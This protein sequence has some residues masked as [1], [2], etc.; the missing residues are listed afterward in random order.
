LRAELTFGVVL[1]CFFLSGFAALL[2]ETVWTRE[3]SFVFGTSEL[4]VATVLAGYMGGLALGAGLAARWTSRVRR[5][6]LAYGLLELGIALSAL[7]VPLAVRASTALTAALFGGRSELPDASGVGIALFTLG[8]SFAILLLPTAMMGATLPMLARHAVRSEQEIGSRVGL[9]YAANTV[10]AVFGA[11]CAAWWLL[12]EL[13]LSG[14]VRVG[15][16]L[17]ALVFVI[18]AVLARHAPALA[19]VDP[20]LAQRPQE[21]EGRAWIL[22]L[23]LASGATSFL[24]EV[25]WVRLLGH[26]LGGS[27]Y[28]FATMLASFLSGIAIGSAAA[29]RIATSRARAARGFALAQLGIAACSFGAFLGVEAFAQLGVRLGVHGA[30]GWGVQVLFSALALGLLLVPATL[31]IGATY[32]LAVR[33]LARRDSEAGPVAARVYAWNTVGAIA[34]SVGAGFWIIPAL[35]YERSLALGVAANL[36]LGAG[37]AVL[38]V[39]PAALRLAVPALLGALALGFLPP[40]TPWG[41]LGRGP[42]DFGAAFESALASPVSAQSVRFLEVGRSATVLLSEEPGAWSLRTNGLP[43]A[44]ILRP[45]M[46]RLDLGAAWL[47]TLPVLARPEAKSMLVIGFGGGALLETV[48]GTLHSI[49]AVEI[50]PAVIEANQVIRGDREIDPLADPRLR[51]TTNDA[52]GALLLTTRRWDIVVSQPSHPWTAGASHLYT[53]DFFSLV[54]AHLNPG[55]V[56]VQWINLEFVDA[57]L[58]RSLVATLNQVFPHVRVYHPQSAQMLLFLG[59]DAAFDMRASVSRAVA[60]APEDMAM[61]GVFTPEDVELYLA[62]DDE[63]ARAFAN[64]AAVSSDDRNLLQTRSP[65]LREPLDPPAA[66]LLFADFEPIARLAGLDHAYL[67]RR[68]QATDS[69]RAARLARDA[70]APAERALV[71]GLAALAAGKRRDGTRQLWSVLETAPDSAA[72]AEARAALASALRSQW[73]AGRPDLVQMAARIPEPA[74]AVLEGWKLLAADDGA[75]VQALDARLAR[76]DPP[77]PMYAHAVRLRAEW[78]LRL[79]DPALAR[80]AGDLLDPLLRL[81]FQPLDLLLRARAAAQAGEDAAALSTLRLAVAAARLRGREQSLAREA[82]RLLDGLSVDDA[83]LRRRLEQAAKRT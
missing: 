13:G 59:S 38:V 12:P 40:P 82:L 51:I 80:E 71:G 14:S 28:A 11:L 65:R 74:T 49:D 9:L 35:G 34:G 6:V 46:P 16:G 47:C 5:P 18:A 41:L 76:V 62:L 68:L 2:Y 54:R 45:R 57:E 3:F 1:L 75:G 83:A 69:G 44:K 79:T 64:G 23:I 50:E 39:R 42:L 61:A 31:F 27:V 58:L 7:A 29:S 53:A 52:R 67:A 26:L 33:V 32:P 20:Q 78:R 56:F 24:Y 30:S 8:C 60:L 36:L 70:F 72:A 4:A 21:T 66:S 15:V 48:P 55:G 17:N 81:Q 73:I 77:D 37:T 10:G 43:E 19:P 22:P 63:G 25:L